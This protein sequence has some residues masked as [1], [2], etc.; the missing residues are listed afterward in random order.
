MSQRCPWHLG[1]PTANSHDSLDSLN[2]VA[3][4]PTETRGSRPIIA[5]IRRIVFAIFL[6]FCCDT[7]LS[8]TASNSSCPTI[9]MEIGSI[10]STWFSNTRIRVLFKGFVPMISEYNSSIQLA[11]VLL[12]FPF[13]KPD[14]ESKAVCHLDGGF[15]R[16]LGGGTQ[17]VSPHCCLSIGFV[18]L[19]HSPR[20]EGNALCRY[21]LS[22]LISYCEAHFLLMTKRL[23]VESLKRHGRSSGWW[24]GLHCLWAYGV[25]CWQTNQRQRK[26]PTSR[27]FLLLSSISL[28]HVVAPSIWCTCHRCSSSIQP[29]FSNARGNTK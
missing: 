8:D 2:S 5:V 9:R 4:A 21:H 20:T 29:T 6:G 28:Q 11:L 22:N 26:I 25:S 1:V 23:H 7:N 15:G 18:P 14:L 16:H 3:A 19:F 13:P 27:I 24:S 17:A 12:K 10:A